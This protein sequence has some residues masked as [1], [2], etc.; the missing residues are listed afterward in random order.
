MSANAIDGLTGFRCSKGKD[1]MTFA[2]WV[3]LRSLDVPSPR[4]LI[5][6]DAP[7]RSNGKRKL[8]HRR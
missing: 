1:A 4:Y 2:R 6:F 8:S 3:Y 7:G 5:R